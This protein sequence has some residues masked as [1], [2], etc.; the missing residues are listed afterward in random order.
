M[1]FEIQVLAL[2]TYLV[3]LNRLIESHPSPLG[4][5]CSL[6]YNKA[7]IDMTILTIYYRSI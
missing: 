4:T 2:E 7:T 6:D 3:G 1:E 5:L